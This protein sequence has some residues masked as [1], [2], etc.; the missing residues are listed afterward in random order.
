MKGILRQQDR[1]L[2]LDPDGGSERL[3]VEFETFCHQTGLDSLEKG[4]IEDLLV[5]GQHMGIKL[6]EL[7]FQVM[8]LMAVFYE[9]RQTVCTESSILSINSIIF[10][11]QKCIVKIQSAG[12]TGSGR[13]KNV[14]RIKFPGFRGKGPGDPV[15]LA[16]SNEN[17]QN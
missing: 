11:V 10:R 16:G 5:I 12:M 4:V 14:R 6:R 8:N 15:I 17:G 9:L 1:K 3:I 7:F 2:C 13:R